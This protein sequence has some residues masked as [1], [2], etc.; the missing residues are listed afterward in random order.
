MCFPSGAGY[1]KIPDK[2]V[3][4]FRSTPFLCRL[5]ATKTLLRSA[6]QVRPSHAEVVQRP[7]NALATLLQDVGGDHGG[8]K[9]VMPEQVLYGADVGAA[10]AQVRR[11]GVATVWALMG[12]VGLARRMLP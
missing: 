10:W 12:F 7:R 4:R 9:I 8:G 3:P 2:V 11:K 5:R 6:D 1:L